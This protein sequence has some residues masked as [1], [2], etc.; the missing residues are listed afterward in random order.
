MPTIDDPLTRET[1]S[2]AAAQSMATVSAVIAGPFRLRGNGV[3]TT[4]DQGG[5]WTPMTLPPGV[6]V[7]SLACPSARVCWAAGSAIVR[8]VD[9][10]AWI[11]TTAPSPAPF[12]NVSSGSAERAAV[13]T[14][15]GVRHVT[16]DGGVTWRPVRP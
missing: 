4:A 15:D 6:R 8:M 9:G 13:T 14:A 7:T 11:R 1:A 10:V 5:T 16:T 12:A 3:E 2:A